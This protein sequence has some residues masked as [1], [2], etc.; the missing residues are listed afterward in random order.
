MKVLSLN[1]RLDARQVR[2]A[3]HRVLDFSVAFLPEG[4]KLDITARRRETDCAQYVELQIISYP[5]DS[6]K[7]DEKR[8]F[9]TLP[10]GGEIQ[11][12]P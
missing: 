8:S 2:S 4:G 5:A 1:V 11:S 10:S 9:S 6:L 12:W 7:I 3:I